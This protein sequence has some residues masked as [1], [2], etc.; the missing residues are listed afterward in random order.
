MEYIYSAMLLHS[1]GK[2]INEA[3][4]KKVIEA[5]GAKAEDVKVKALVAALDGVNIEEVISKAAMPVAVAA[6]AA[7]E[8]PK[9]H[10]KEEPSPEDQEKKAEEAAGGLAS[11]F[12]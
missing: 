10:K 12:G 11:L 9:E 2:E 5:A 8:A 7:V 3:N 1:S 4:V 6:P